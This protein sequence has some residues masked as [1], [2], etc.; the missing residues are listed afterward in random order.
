MQAEAEKVPAGGS[1]KSGIVELTHEEATSIEIVLTKERLA[2]AEEKLAAIQ[3]R[4]AQK[5]LMEVARAKAVLM[6]KLGDR[7]GGRLNSAKIVGKHRLAY[8]LE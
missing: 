4:E 7:L 2:A 8:E 3:L 1:N 6:S 5:R